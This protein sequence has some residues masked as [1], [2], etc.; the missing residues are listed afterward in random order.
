MAIGN[1]DIALGRIGWTPERF[2]LDSL[3][4]TLTET[5][6]FANPDFTSDLYLDVGVSIFRYNW[7]YRFWPQATVDMHSGLG[8]RLFQPLAT[9]PKP[10]SWPRGGGSR[11]HTEL[12]PSVLEVHLDHSFTYPLFPAMNVYLEGGNGLA[13]AY[14]YENTDEEQVLA[15]TAWTWK[16]GGGIQFH[17]IS[18]GGSRLSYGLEFLYRH[19]FFDYSTSGS[20]VAGAANG[21]YDTP[22]ISADLSHAAVAFTIGFL[23]GGNTNIAYKGYLAE[24]RRD[25]K[26]AIKLYRDFL[27][28]NPKHHNTQEVKTRLAQVRNRLPEQYFREA[29]AAYKLKEYTQAEEYLSLAGK[30]DDAELIGKVNELRRAVGKI[31]LREAQENLA[32][33]NFT[34]AESRLQSSANLTPELERPARFLRAKLALAKGA[35][36][37]QNGLY[38]RALYWLDSA[39]RA[40]PG[41]QGDVKAYKSKIAQGM[42]VD[43]DR[44]VAEAN[45]VLARESLKGAAGLDPHLAYILQEPIQELDTSLELDKL[46]GL[47]AL[48]AWELGKYLVRSEPGFTKADIRP[49][50]GMDHL[51]LD[52][53]GARPQQVYREGQSELWV[54]RYADGSRL[55]VYL[56]RGVVTRVVSQ[57]GD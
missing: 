14:L 15:T 54:Y 24:Q 16:L 32:A 42:V 29:L 34:S 17:R 7:L 26:Q 46:A 56:D 22:I 20:R 40:N 39:Q 4:S 44:S 53:L 30:T 27:N 10:S 6:E 33:L 8:F 52:K 50:V 5:A 49:Q 36:L 43:A 21:A 2:V 18:D 38:D 1:T 47:D 57:P 28:Q 41:F 11:S 37:Y 13:R 23:F 3:E 31:Y 19:Q 45:K 55:Q 25:Y 35:V 9:M 51:V 48:T 12:S